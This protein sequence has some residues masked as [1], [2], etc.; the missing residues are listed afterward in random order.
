M[1]EF[2]WRL[3]DLRSGKTYELTLSA[4]GDQSVY[5]DSEPSDQVDFETL[6]LPSLD[7]PEGLALTERLLEWDV[8]DNAEGYEVT[9]VSDSG[10]Y[11]PFTYKVELS[12]FNFN[13]HPECRPGTI[14]ANV[15]AL[16]D[17]VVYSDS[18]EATLEAYLMENP[19]AEQLPAPTNIM[20]DGATN[21]LSWDAVEN[22]TGYAVSYFEGDKEA[23]SAA[24]T[25]DVTSI[26]EPLPDGDYTFKV[27]AIGDGT[28]Y[29]NSEW[30]EGYE[31]SIGAEDPGTD[32]DPGVDP[33]VDPGT[34][35]DPGTEPD[36]GVDPGTDPGSDP[37]PGDD[38]G[39]DPGTDPDPGVDPDPGTDPEP[40]PTIKTYPELA[41]VYG[42][43]YL[44]TEP[45]TVGYL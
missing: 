42:F 22:A 25:G 24:T 21:T 2:E 4:V 34:D 33:G 1:D 40:T 30:S 17:N 18:T 26:T 9:I 23:Q 11:G 31:V 37:N 29:S 35:P 13:D 45:V 16:G 15:I 32:P 19:M 36:P 6:P 43:G 39:V 41:E 7:S 27:M 38:P 14:T 20:W 5:G 8:V 10:S 44:T 12:S 3:V 28:N